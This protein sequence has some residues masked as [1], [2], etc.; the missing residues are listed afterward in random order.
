MRWVFMITI[1]IAVMPVSSL[2]AI[3]GPARVIDGDTIEVEGQRIRLHG[4]DAPEGRQLCFD[5][6]EPWLCGTDATSALRNKISDRQV[7]CEEIDR[8]RYER[9]VA[10]CV[11]DGEDLGEWMVLRGWAV[12]YVYYSYEYT[13]A[14][15]IA[16]SREQGIWASE[17]D[18]PW[19]WRQAQRNAEI[20]NA[21]DCRIKGNIN[22][23]GERIY[24][25]PGGQLYDLVKV[26]LDKGE[27][28]FC[29][30]ADAQAAG[31]RASRQ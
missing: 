3:T 9:I 19:D 11:V 27:R 2:A 4:I 7:T 26:K 28:W 10:R 29:S 5:D 1:L 23:K 13:R 31:W 8:D 14:E 12:A 22:A 20:G 21:A 25:T 30:E 6:G 15:A 17:F 18:M 24:H 16:K